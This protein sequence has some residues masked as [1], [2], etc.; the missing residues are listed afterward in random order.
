MS[1]QRPPA[2]HEEEEQ[3]QQTPL[4]KAA[5]DAF[6]VAAAY[7]REVAHYP[8]Y[9]EEDHV[10]DAALRWVVARLEEKITV[11]QGR[12]EAASDIKCLDVGCVHGRPTVQVLAEQGYTV[13]GLDLE[14]SGLLE[15]ARRSG[16]RAVWVGGD[17]RGWEPPELD[18]EGKEVYDAVTCFVFDA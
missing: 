5:F 9:A 4:P 7:S 14:G 12:G 11:Q 2:T 10:R 1:E 3:P 8:L 15:V 16:M 13:T 18:D 17:V 6:D